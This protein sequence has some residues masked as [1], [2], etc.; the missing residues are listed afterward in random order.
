MCPVDLEFAPDGSLYFIDWHNP[1]IGHMQHNLRDPSRDRAHGRVYRIRH[2]N[3]LLETPVSEA[4]MTTE[5]LVSRLLNPATDERAAYRSRIELTGRDVEEVG[6]A[7]QDGLQANPPGK[8]RERLQLLWLSRQINQ[9]PTE[10][11]GELCHCG[12]ERVRAAAVRV[13]TDCLDRVPEGRQW[14]LDAAGDPHP[15]VRMLA[16]R[17]ASFME[18]VEALEIIA[19]AAGQ[20]RD[21]FIDYVIRES[22]RTVPTSWRS[23]LVESGMLERL[24]TESQ[25]FLLEQLG[26]ARISS[27]P[28]TAANAGFMM[29]AE[30]VT[31]EQRS[32]A[33]RSFAKSSNKPVAEVLV[34]WMGLAAANP[35]HQS[36]VGE[37]AMM[38]GMQ[39]SE[40]LGKVRS[41]LEAFTA[42]NTNF[43]LQR[44]GWL[45][46]ILADGE[47]GPALERAGTDNG[48]LISLART[49]ELIPD[50]RLQQALF[51]R[52]KGDLPALQ[53]RIS[54]T[55]P[56]ITGTFVRV[57]LPGP[58]RIL[59]LAE[60]EVFS[61]GNN[62]ARQGRA[63]QS[64]TSHNGDPARAV[65]GNTS[66]IY[67]QGSQTHT[68]ETTEN[69]WWQVRL[70]QPSPIN[71]IR[72]HNR[73]EGNFF[74]R[75]DGFTVKVL[76]ADRKIL[77]EK[78]SI[79]ASSEPVDITIQA[80]SPE[81]QLFVAIVDSLSHVRSREKE[82]FEFLAGCL[83]Q[84]TEP[85]AAVKSI[86][87]LQASAWNPARAKEIAQSVLARMSAIPEADREGDF[88]ARLY[89][90]G[91]F[92]TSLLPETER[93][94]VIARLGKLSV[95]V[96][97]VGTR[98]HRMEY[99][100][101]MLAVEPGRRFAI[102]FENT[103]AMP[104]NLVLI[105]PG[106]LEHIGLQAEVESI[107]PD[108]LAKN[109]VP[110]SGEVIAST[111]LIQP[112]ETG[113]ISLQAP[114]EPG[115]Y[116]YI[117][118]YPG[119]WRR[120]VGSLYVVSSVEDFLAAPDAYCESN[121]IRVMDEL[122]RLNANRREW[123]PDDFADDFSDANPAT[124]LAGRSFDRGRELFRTASCGSCHKLAG[125]G[126]TLGPD[127]AE[128]DPLWKP[129]DVLRHILVPSEKID[130]KYR[131]QI[132]LLLSGN[133]VSG[134]VTEENDDA[135]KLTD[136][137]LLQSS[138]QVIPID[139]I[140]DRS[141]S[142]I[143]MM[144]VGLLDTLS[145]SDIFDLLAYVIAKGDSKH[146]TYS[147]SGENKNAPNR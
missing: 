119:H 47:V 120:M 114:T 58:G 106:M 33:V 72:I 20:P 98:P 128:M 95:P 69:P 111:R 134:I 65:D 112:G 90:T 42:D 132:L 66:G 116:P 34:E 100:R 82:A 17:G 27:V 115:V 102:V 26:P 62:I 45:G 110:S 35:D 146:P 136:N 78:T 133:T 12:D 41:K 63:G 131:T 138:V 30:G 71:S 103:D 49:V 83:V 11:I 105:Q 143:S 22:M 55:S 13:L 73:T 107:R 1:I 56:E 77:F 88:A 64:S 144:P 109:Y 93:A 37:L 7:I 130:D 25:R 125:E 147:E 28:V 91:Q 74:S 16:A 87:R 86:L 59:T 2:T 18:S 85:E 96:L 76:D 44:A 5:T 137:P 51:D 99:D 129:A 127:L 57:E 140:D 104:H 21:Q 15:R 89:Q 48:Q 46:M 67:S 84:G 121:N 139:D 38:L 19:T 79:P 43:S 29:T 4:E 23:K 145:R 68:A 124:V 39:P 31:P 60:V 135:V 9:V 54:G 101:T 92:A 94:D 75:M 141:I 52:L 40:E 108:A 53:T 6:K 8:N 36:A 117:C 32:A 97:S 70:T 24:G 14:L 122:L 3:P 80:V 61:N 10:L 113:R 123:K 126:F 118:T 81:R 50:P 142:T